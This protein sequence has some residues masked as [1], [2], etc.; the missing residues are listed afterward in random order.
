MK[1]ISTALSGVCVLQPT[2]Y[3]DDRGFFMESFNRRDFAKLVGSTPDFVQHNHSHSKHGVIRGLHYQLRH[4]QGKLVRVTSGEIY[5][6]AVDLR[7]HSPTFGQWTS[8]ILSAQNRLQLW[9]PPGFAHGFAVTSQTADVVYNATAYYAPNDERC[10]RWNDP[11]LNIHWPIS[12]PTLSAKDQAGI[13]F[14]QAKL[15]L[16]S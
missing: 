15:E 4:P 9:I 13:S 12:S 7:P 16:E 6:V 11:A 3:E 14:N 8:T 2:V 1:L 10:L 5:D